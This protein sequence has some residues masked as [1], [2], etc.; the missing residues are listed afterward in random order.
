M[1][2]AKGTVSRAVCQAAIHPSSLFAH[3]LLGAVAIIPLFVV[4][5]TV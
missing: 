5:E 1:G 2:A 3:Y 4:L